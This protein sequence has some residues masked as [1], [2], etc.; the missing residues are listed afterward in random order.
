MIFGMHVEPAR[1]SVLDAEH[2]AFI[3]QPGISMSAASCSAGKV[4]RLGRLLGCRVAS[5]RSRVAVLL[6]GDQLPELV[7]ALRE[8]G[9]IAVV[10]SE[11]PHAP[12]DPAQGQRCRDRRASA[13][14]CRFVRALRR[15]LWS[16]RSA[17]GLSGIAGAAPCSQCAG[18]RRGGA[19]SRPCGVPA[20]ARAARR[21]A[22]P[23]M[24]ASVSRR[25]HHATAWK[26]PSRRSSPPARPMARPTSSTSRRCTTST[27]RMSRC[28]SSSSTRRARTCWPIRAPRCW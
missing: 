24:N 16:P 12:H 15:R 17:A 18:G 25:R 2:A 20:D 10:F 4:P 5:D 1:P 14:R 23:T 11:P 27:P 7:Q 8:S 19:R 9:A 13:R 28:R 6:P 22:A 3:V 21:H 26:A